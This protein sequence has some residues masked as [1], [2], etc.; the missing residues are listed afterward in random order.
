MNPIVWLIPAAVIAGAPTGR[1]D[2]APV[3]QVLEEQDVE[4]AYPH[5]SKDAKRVLFQSNE[6][7]R[8]QIYVM[9][10]DGGGITQLT[11]DEA[12][13]NLPDWSPDNGEICFVSD[14]D[15]NE[16]IYVMKSD[17]SEPRRLTSTP[18]REIHPYWTPSGDKIL[19]NSDRSGRGDLDVYIMNGDGSSP[20]RLTDTPDDETCARESPDGTQIVYLRNNEFG[21]DD[22]FLM[23]LADS[24]VTNLTNT[25]SRDGWPCWTPSGEGIIF[26]AAK[27]GGYKLYHMELKTGTLTPLTNPAP[28]AYDARANISADGG[29]IIFNR[30]VSGAKNTIGIYVLE[31][32]SPW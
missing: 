9:N 15:G 5:W 14:R 16:E 12:N 30:Q 18:G 19:F 23:N 25:P 13:N 4:Y 32:A 21:L 31:L 6:N 3:A 22:V 11:T 28:P 17:G 1:G 10:A 27:D 2:F 26:S 8:W 20:V 29:K 7:G 24:S